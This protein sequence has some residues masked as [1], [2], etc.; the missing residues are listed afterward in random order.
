MRWN[1]YLGWVIVSLFACT[2][3]ETGRPE[4]TDQDTEEIR[5]G[6]A[7]RAHPAVGM[8]GVA[9]SRDSTEVEWICS[10][11][12][13]EPRVVLTAAH[14]LFGDSRRRVGAARVRFTVEDEIFRAT[15]TRVAPTYSPLGAID[16]DD[17]ALLK[18][19]REP[20]LDP[21]PASTAVPLEG[22]RAAVVGYGVTS[23]NSEGQGR[24]GGTRR[25]AAIVIDTVGERELFYDAEERGA[26]YGDSG[27]PVL[28][29]L[30]DGEVVVGVTSRGTRVECDGANIATRVDI[31]EEWIADF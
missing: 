29:D 5:G 21:I 4:E 26:C 10:G 9:A 7:D 25:R 15:R 19:D 30:G 20:V 3:A 2:G 8:V 24:G 18:L 11:T 22:A 16:Q 23:A 17:I 27:G 6:R 14:C 12:L 1:A 13:V 28:Q 31:F